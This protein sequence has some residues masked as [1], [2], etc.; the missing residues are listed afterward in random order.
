MLKLKIKAKS[1]ICN[2]EEPLQ[3]SIR[4][5][6]SV[7][8]YAPSKDMKKFAKVLD[9]KNDITPASLVCR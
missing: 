2:P 7:E 4:R 8:I 9:P 6:G 3:F 1:C 5:D